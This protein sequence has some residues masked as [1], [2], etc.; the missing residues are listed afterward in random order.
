M[1]PNQD[2]ARR[3]V[4]TAM[5]AITPIGN[6]SETYW[7]NLLSGVSGAGP[8]TTFDT[9]G[10]DVKIAAE[11]KG[12]DPTLTMDRKMVRRMSRF[13]HFGV[14]AATE[15]I[16]RSGL[17]FA[18]WTPEQRDRVA[19]VI[20]TGGGGMEQV[21]DGAATLWAKGP[22]QVSPF[23]IPAV[24]GS[25]AAA[26]VSMKYGLTGPLMTQVAACASGVIAFQDALRLIATGEC[27]V[28]IAGGSEAP[29]LPMAFAALA[30]MGALSKRNEDPEGASRPFDRTRD[31]F[32]FG[33]GAGVLVIESAAH[34]LERGAPILAEI[35]G[36]KLTADA[37]HISAPEP[38][39]R[40][41]AM[42]MTGAMQ[43]AGIGPSDIDYLVAHGT[44][45]PLNDVTET[46]AI[47]RA[48]GE[49][50]GTLPI[51]SPKSMVGH[52]LGAAGAVAGIAAVGAIRDGWIPPTINYREPDPD[53]DLDYTPNVKRRLRVDTAMINGFGFG[54][55]NAVAIFRRFDD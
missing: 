39:G 6:D 49:R 23:A 40:G 34:A 5:G 4:V 50:A 46:K 13:I 54:G 15:A 36:A 30:N 24:S 14:A 27:D 37:F 20:N 41:A 16:E 38:T 2:P 8:I 52:L 43:H 9:T 51:S 18:A 29:L 17:D 47:K 53:C 10:H 11:V 28:V 21:I 25:M 33:E 32:V 35:I 3:A 42:A 48:F 26:Q 7:T 44:S 1:P 55:Q 22:G 31:G 45:T 12:F 19:V